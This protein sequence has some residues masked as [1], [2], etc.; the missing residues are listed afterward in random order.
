M[1][2]PRLRR[3]HRVPMPPKHARDPRPRIHPYNISHIII[4]LQ[5]R[6]L[7]QRPR[8][9]GRWV[10]AGGDSEIGVTL[11]ELGPGPGCALAPEVD[12]GCGL[13]VG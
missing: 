3:I 1:L 11:G 6:I 13:S 5:G 8:R 2:R 7:V 9:V 12:G 4:S 10:L